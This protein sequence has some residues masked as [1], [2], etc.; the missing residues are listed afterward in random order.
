MIY[1]QEINIDQE[2]YKKTSINAR[3]VVI[4]HKRDYKTYTNLLT[5]K[6]DKVRHKRQAAES[7][8]CSVVSPAAAA[9]ETW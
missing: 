3:T 7:P 5:N 2:I 6:P 4:S 8:V 9:R 1:D